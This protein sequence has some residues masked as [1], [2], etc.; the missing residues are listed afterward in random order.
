[1][2]KGRR[3]HPRGGY[4]TGADTGLAL[5][6]GEPRHVVGPPLGLDGS[7]FQPAERRLGRGFTGLDDRALNAGVVRD[8][9]EDRR[10]LGRF[11]G[12]VEPRYSAGMRSRWLAVRGQSASTGRQPGQYG[13]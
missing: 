1:M 2:P 5:V 3:Y 6:G 12:E 10:R 4:S 7:A 8:G 9:V 11:E 13:P